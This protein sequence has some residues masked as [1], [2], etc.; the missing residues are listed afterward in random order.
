MERPSSFSATYTIWTDGFDTQVCVLSMQH[1]I[2][3]PTDRK[4]IQ[5]KKKQSK[6]LKKMS[7]IKTNILREMGRYYTHVKGTGSYEKK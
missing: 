5:R 4:G 7:K 6:E 3:K 2:V 1:E